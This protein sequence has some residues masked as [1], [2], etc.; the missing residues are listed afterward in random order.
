LTS[1][2]FLNLIPLLQ[3]LVAAD[4][5]YTLSVEEVSEIIAGTDAL[6]ARGIK[7]EEDI[8]KVWRGGGGAGGSL[9]LCCKQAGAAICL[10]RLS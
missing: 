4:Y 1:P 10:A 7:E 6:L 8:K 9:Q 3:D 5:T 2:F